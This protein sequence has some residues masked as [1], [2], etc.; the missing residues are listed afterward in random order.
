MAAVAVEWVTWAGWG[1]KPRAYLIRS[2]DEEGRQRCW[3]FL[4]VRYKRVLARTHGYARW[5]GRALPT[6]EQ[7]E[8]A[9]QG[10]GRKNAAGLWVANTWQGS[11]PSRHTS[12]DAK[13][14]PGGNDPTQ[15]D[16]RDVA[17]VKGGS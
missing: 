9:A 1:C 15:A 2:F 7:F 16:E 13:A 3:P 4:L 10:G 6:E 12:A 5:K 8:Y 17:V 11:F 14:H